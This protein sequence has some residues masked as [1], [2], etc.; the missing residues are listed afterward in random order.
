MTVKESNSIQV[1]IC[2]WIHKN[3]KPARRFNREYGRSMMLLRALK[4]DVPRADHEQFKMAMAVCGYYADSDNTNDTYSKVVF[5]V[6]T[7]SAKKVLYNH[8][9]GE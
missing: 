9:K 7:E 3:L 1:D 6:T 8:K 4:R 2:M 5:N